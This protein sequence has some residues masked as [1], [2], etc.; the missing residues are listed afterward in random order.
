MK[1]PIVLI[2]VVVAIWLGWSAYQKTETSPVVKIGVMAPLTG[3]LASYGQSVKMA[4]EFA[5]ETAGLE[6]VELI[7]E[8]SKCEGKEAASVVNKLINIDGVSAIIGELCSGATLAAAPIADQS[9]VVL[10]SPASTSPDITDA[11]EY[12]FR[13]IPSDAL[14]GSFAAELVTANDLSRLAV[15]YTNDDYG[16]GFEGVLQEEFPK[17][18]GEIVASE[19]VEQGST[20]ARTQL[21]K[22]RAAN[23]DSIYIIS[24]STAATVT[25]LKQINEVGL[26][27]I[28]KFGSEGLRSPDVTQGAGVAAEG[29]IVSSVSAGTT[30]FINKYA[31]RYGEQPGP[32]AA[33]SYDAFM[34][35]SQAITAGAV[36]GLSIQA[37]LEDVSYD[38]ASGMIDFD[39]NGDITGGYDVVI[40]K[41]G[42]FLPTAQ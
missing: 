22:I 42:K 28:A 27:Q 4:V 13:T 39:E 38:G 11:G 26:N 40:V 20:D 9:Q 10:I 8:D 14:Q 41:D 37:A 12:I 15:I 17:L 29:L 24:N 23:P 35:L 18:G 36:D 34:V 3:D 7:I 19:A 30:D 16:Q 6:N 1:K 32:F 2:L 21:T 25:I 33:Q 31:E 5:A